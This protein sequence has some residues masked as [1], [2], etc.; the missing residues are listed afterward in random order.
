MLNSF[1]HYL[2]LCKELRYDW[3]SDAVLVAYVVPVDEWKYETDARGTGNQLGP[4][5]GLVDPWCM[6]E[7]VDRAEAAKE[8]DRHQR[9]GDQ[10]YWMLL[11]V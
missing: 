6:A 4:Q 5:G 3:Y 10:Q 9:V 11:L 2:V 8:A 7:A 1:E